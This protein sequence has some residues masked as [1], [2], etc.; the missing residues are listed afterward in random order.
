MASSMTERKGHTS[1]YRRHTIGVGALVILTL[2]TR[3]ASARDVIL[4]IGDGMGLSQVAAGRAYAVGTEGSLT[5]EQIKRHGTATTHSADSAITDSAASA[6]ALATG[7]KTYN[8]A[9]AVAMDGSDLETILEIA[10]S[11]GKATG[12]VTTTGLTHATPASFGAHEAS[13]NSEAQIAQDYV[14][15]SRPDVLLG[16]GALYWSGALLDE[17]GQAGYEV[18]RSGDELRAAV[19][20]AIP[21]SKTLGLFSNGHMTYELDRAAASSE[22]HL[23]D[24]VESALSMLTTDPD[25]FFLMVEGGRIDHAC[26]SNDLERATL[27]VEAFDRAIEA[28][29]NWTQVSAA[30]RDNTLVI[31]TADHET[32]G[33]SLRNPDDVLQAGQFVSARWTTTGH[34]AADVPIWAAGPG[35][36]AVGG[37]MDNIDIFPLML[38][39]M[40]GPP[41]TRVD[42]RGKQLTTLGAIKANA[43]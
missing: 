18:V 43:P 31:V 19:A 11:R 32:G 28:V 6:T 30:R 3:A 40:S 27:E 36:E 26:H 39:A 13:R 24:M 41:P 4:M 42:L 12:L 33:M 17:A 16:G 29:L 25:G 14:H 35:S 10:Q 7:V 22:P 23:R 38:D 9:I 21:G 34:S 20:A 1:A 2:L 37:Q 5:M 8:G 15:R